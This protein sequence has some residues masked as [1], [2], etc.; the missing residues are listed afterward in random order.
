MDCDDV[1]LLLA[2]P[3]ETLT[4]HEATQ[5]DEHVDGC[6]RCRTLALDTDEEHWRW[7]ARLPEDAF[8]D[9]DLLVLPVV[10][11]AVFEP[12]SEL[13][14]GGMGRITR[15][16]DRRLGREVA[17]KE[18]LD[19]DLRARFEREATI[20][21]RLQHPAIVPVYEAGAWPNGSAFY[22][23]RLVSGGTLARAIDRTTTLAERLALVPH[24]VAVTDALAYAHSQRIIHRDLKPQNVLVGEFGETVVIDWGLAKE[25]DHDVEAAVYS[26]PSQPDA[27]LTVVGSVMGTPCFMPPEQARGEDLDERADVFALGAI[28]YNVL[29]GEPPY[30]DRDRDTPQKLI[31][32]VLQTPPTPIAERAPDAPAD[33]RAVV[34]R[35]MARDKRDRY[36]T[37]KEMA[38]ELRRFQA[39][40]LLVSREYRLRDHLV[41]WVRRHRAPVIVASIAAVVLA[42]VGVVALVN[43]TRSRDA[44]RDSRIAAED[45]RGAADRSVA[46]LLEEQGR[47]ELLGGHRDRALAYLAASYS[48]GHDSTALRHLLA[49]ATR[50]TG[51][52]QHSL[53]AR[54]DRYTAVAFRSDHELVAFAAADKARI[55]VW[56]G[57]AIVDSFGLGVDARDATFSVDGGRVLVVADTAL[58]GVDTATGKQLWQLAGDHHSDRFAFDPEGK[59]FAIVTDKD[60]VAIYALDTGK[61]AGKLVTEDKVTTAAAFSLD[62][63]FVATCSDEGLISVWQLDPK[64]SL[65][66]SLRI[67][68]ALTDIAFAGVQV[69]VTTKEREIYLWKAGEAEYHVLGGHRDDVTAITSSPLGNFIA[70]GDRSGGVKLW[71]EKG[72]LL[73]ETSEPRGEIQFLH[74]SP[75]LTAL[76]GGGRDPRTYVWNMSLGVR[77]ILQAPD[78]QFESIAAVAWGPKDSIATVDDSGKQIH[79]WKKPMANLIAHE[80][81]EA[82][83]ISAQHVVIVHDDTLTVRELAHG[84]LV[85][86]I[87]KVRMH[88]KPAQYH[89]VDRSRVAVDANA[90]RALV[91]NDKGATVYALTTTATPRALDAD[92]INEGN[93]VWLLASDGT[94]AV[95]LGMKRIR[96][97]DTTSG[98]VVMSR[99]MPEAA[100]PGGDLSRDG[101]HLV[102]AATTPLMWQVP[103]GAPVAMKELEIMKA[104]RRKGGGTVWTSTGPNDI[105]FDPTGVR[106]LVLQTSLPVVVD[107]ATGTTL[108]RLEGWA[109][110]DEGALDD[111]GHHAITQALGAVTLWDVDT[112]DAMFSVP[113]TADGAFA[114]S[115]DGARLATG[116]PDGT[117][118][119]WDARGRLLETIHG[120]RAA[121][122]SLQF[123]A[124]NTRLVALG[125]DHRISVWDVHLEQRPAS[126]IAAVARKLSAWDVVGGALVARKTP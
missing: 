98:A 96:V 69:A 110:V 103:S 114:I 86:T 35:A 8:D 62:G 5:L 41:R 119:I 10:D 59:R 91:W 4:G 111:G 118:Q 113:G 46:A 25:L 9:P 100:G 48:R 23:M 106:C 28:L 101:T 82:V 112:G 45:A 116:H 77:G 93:A 79:V 29:C 21:A 121:I 108:R 54:D 88:E 94:H 40:Q 115:H 27:K 38:E 43:V 49:E 64:P 85:K 99:D 17:I 16:R 20:T 107:A 58:L 6:E 26:R 125:G 105:V 15:A 55:D 63:G 120:H 83:A 2:R 126:D 52:L 109:A 74:F 37:A 124:D 30:W 7:V 66:G 56:H 31:D 32:A 123:S 68:R 67:P 61:L 95:E 42:A 97:H 90:T 47:S 57:D 76:V 84:K 72:Q 53:D 22:T 18:V 71:D 1:I 122:A 104:T 34:E 78:D 73:G 117:V 36:A 50:D 11:P 87:E 65:G 33:L 92:P 75:D 70:T 3:A 24:V 51:L 102:V 89:Q 12:G 80:H 13:A 44:E 81:G 39:G 14:S 19:P 60:P